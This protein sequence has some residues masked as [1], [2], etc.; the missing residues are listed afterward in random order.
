MTRAAEAIQS[1]ATSI[2]R[3]GSL[4]VGAS[5][6]LE[7]LNEFIG[8]RWNGELI[9]FTILVSS[10]ASSLAAYLLAGIL[11]RYRTLEIEVYFSFLTGWEDLFVPE[12]LLISSSIKFKNE[13][14][15][16]I[17]NTLEKLSID[18]ETETWNE[19]CEN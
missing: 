7:R 9:G 3:A 5:S 2:F 8:N 12:I 15:L 6:I 11:S 17:G 16:F 19:Y 4:T 14:Y 18:F 1:A 13:F 10:R